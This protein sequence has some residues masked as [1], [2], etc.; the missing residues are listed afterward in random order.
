MHSNG[1]CDML[2]GT[3][4]TQ[5]FRKPSIQSETSGCLCNGSF[6]SLSHPILLRSF[7][8]SEMPLDAMLFA[9]FQEFTIP[10]LGA[11][12]SSKVL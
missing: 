4:D 2:H 7:S 8:Y 9:K 3:S 5:D 11:I 1:T 12:I 6:E 10:V